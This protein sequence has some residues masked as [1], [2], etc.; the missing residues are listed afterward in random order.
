MLIPFSDLTN[1]RTTNIDNYDMRTSRDDIIQ[2]FYETLA[3]IL[4]FFWFKQVLD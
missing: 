1:E 2:T 3:T 4:A